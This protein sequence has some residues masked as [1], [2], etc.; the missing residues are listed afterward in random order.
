MLDPKLIR[1]DIKTV[2]CQLQKRGMSLDIPYL[3]SLEEKR[4]EF[5]TT[6]Q[7]LQNERNVLSKAVGQAK[8][9]NKDASDIMQQVKES[10]DKLKKTEED[11]EHIQEELNSYLATF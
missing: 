4:K 9:A 2:A 7:H 11:F 5:Q 3:N 6:L 10:G 1:N 8:A